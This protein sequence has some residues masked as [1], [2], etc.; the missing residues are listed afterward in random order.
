[1][2]AA[3]VRLGDLEQPRD[4]G[5]DVQA[6]AGVLIEPVAQFGRVP[7]HEPEGVW[8]G[9]VTQ[10]WAA[11]QRA[12][13]ARQV[14]VTGFLERR[15]ERERSRDEPPRSR[16]EVD[17]L[18]DVV[19]PAEDAGVGADL[20]RHGP[21]HRGEPDLERSVAGRRADLALAGALHGQRLAEER[22]EQRE[23]VRDRDGRGR[24]SGSGAR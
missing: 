9:A 19:A 6:P 20:H 4:L 3:R 2:G 23:R 15:V 13:G 24:S 22:Q 7:A 21:G 17:D 14:A 5:V 1:M 16:R 18:E 10:E 11:Q 12:G 8:V